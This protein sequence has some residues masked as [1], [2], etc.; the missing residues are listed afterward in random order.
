VAIEGIPGPPAQGIPPPFRDVE[1][2]IHTAVLASRFNISDAVFTVCKHDVRVKFMPTPVLSGRPAAPYR[3]DEP[4]SVAAP[5]V[6]V[7]PKW[8]KVARH[9]DRL[10]IGA[11]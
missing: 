4:R 7:F 11:D 10:L 9:R 8:I 3:A 5:D 1:K 6:N 2:V